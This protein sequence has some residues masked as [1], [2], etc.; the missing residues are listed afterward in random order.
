MNGRSLSA[1]EVGRKKKY[2]KGFI[3]LSVNCSGDG[4]MLVILYH[5]I[6]L[7]TKAR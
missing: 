2:P 1:T 3:H 5:S 6:S 4:D 7:L